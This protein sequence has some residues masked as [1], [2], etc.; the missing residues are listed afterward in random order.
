MNTNSSPG[1]PALK[2]SI[3][4]KKGLESL[5]MKKT[6]TFASEKANEDEPKSSISLSKK[7]QKRKLSQKEL[8]ARVEPRYLNNTTISTLAK[9]EIDKRFKPL[10]EDEME[11][12]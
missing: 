10:T 12:K 4:M 1:S 2:S 9:Q 3:S 5:S 8:L 6:I 7:P 11:A